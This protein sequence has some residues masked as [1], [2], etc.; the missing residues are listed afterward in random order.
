[1]T[2]R[3][4]IFISHSSRDKEYVRRLALDL[5]SLGLKVWLDEWEIKVGEPITQG[6]QSGL[7]HCDYIAVWLTKQA[8]QSRWVE[9]EWQAKYHEEVIKGTI[10]V[11]PLL[12]EDCE[13]PILLSDKKYA[14]FR[15]D[16][17]SGLGELLKVLNLE[18][19]ERL[20][21]E[22]RAIK[23]EM[24]AEIQGH[25]RLSQYMLNHIFEETRG[26]DLK[27][28]NQALRELIDEGSVKT[29][30]ELKDDESTIIC[31]AGTV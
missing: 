7:V 4:S 12:A 29:V 27:A 20:E 9:R 3:P 10:I 19:L 21:D 31:I 30:G 11:L 13:I 8:V 5:R 22:I 24:L 6:I 14:D 18:Y 28:C 25:G 16:Y 26:F 15:D 23:P 1:M 17:D 2:F